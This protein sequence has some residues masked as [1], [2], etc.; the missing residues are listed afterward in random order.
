MAQVPLV[1]DLYIRSPIM[2]VLLMPSVMSR[3]L[4]SEF[5]QNIPLRV[6]EP[7]VSVG[8]QP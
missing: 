6:S 3:N 8:I 7:A 2:R 1:N 5:I 4:V